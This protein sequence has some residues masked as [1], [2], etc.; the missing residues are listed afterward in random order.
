MEENKDYQED[1]KEN[2]DILNDPNDF[3]DEEKVEV[4]HQP[5]KNKA[6]P[7]RNFFKELKRIIWPTSKKNWKYFFLV[8]AFIIFLVIIFAVVSWCVNGIWNVIGAN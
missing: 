1:I 8:F 5:N 3:L 2:I 7:V 6:Y 4:E